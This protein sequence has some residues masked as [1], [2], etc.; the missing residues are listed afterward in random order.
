MCT[1][2]V[3]LTVKRFSRKTL[4]VSLWEGVGWVKCYFDCRKLFNETPSIFCVRESHFYSLKIIK[5]PLIFL[6]SYFNGCKVF[7]EIP[8]P[9]FLLGEVLWQ[10]EEKKE[11]NFLGG[12]GIVCRVACETGVLSQVV[13]L[14]TQKIVPSCLKRVKVEQSWEISGAFPYTL[15]L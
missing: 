5:E 15:V 12:F 13:I 11:S 8:S 3:I 14:K 9:F 4:C 1:E 2:K 10:L 7:W 6:E